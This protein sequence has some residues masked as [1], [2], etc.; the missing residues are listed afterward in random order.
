MPEKSNL[1]WALYCFSAEYK[2]QNY[3]LYYNY[4]MGNQPLA[5]ATD[6]FRDTFGNVFREFSENACGPVVDSLSDR[7]VVTG[8]KST[9]AEM[10]IEEVGSNVP[11]PQ[12]TLPAAMGPTPPTPNA[13]GRKKVTQ[14]DP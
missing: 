14:V 2:M 4:Y 5:F 6:K 7:L 9:E 8:F 11:T 10:K 3:L 12:P 1:E 13:P